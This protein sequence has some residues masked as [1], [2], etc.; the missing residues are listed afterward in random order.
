LKA[1][2]TSGGL[3]NLKQWFNFVALAFILVGNVTPV[4][5]IHLLWGEKKHPF[6]LKYAS[7]VEIVDKTNGEQNI[8]LKRQPFPISFDESLS[9]LQISFDKKSS[10]IKS[11]EVLK[12]QYK[13]KEFDDSIGEAASFDQPLHEM[14]VAPADF[15]FLNQEKNTGDFTIYFR[16][17]PYQLKRHMDVF[18]KAGVFEGRKQGLVCGWEGGKLFYDF[19][20]LF[21]NR[22]NPVA[23][24]RISTR[25]PFQANRFYSV[26]LIY[27]QNDGSLTLYLDGVEQ[28]KIYVTTDFSPHGGIL[29]P[30]FH[31][32][33][34]SP[35]IIGKNY[36][37]ALDDMIFSN[38][39]LNPEIISGRFNRVEKKGARFFQSPGVAVSNRIDLPASQSKIERLKYD[40]LKPQGTDVKFYYRYSDRPFFADIDEMEFPYLPLASEKLVHVKGKYFQW[41]AEL[42]ADATG[43]LT[44]VVNKVNLQYS[45]NMAP[46]APGEIS[47]LDASESEVT[48]EFARSL[49][50]DVVD[51]GR[52]HV[53]YG[54]KP[55]Q[56]LGAI[57]YK[58]FTDA[59]GRLQGVPI[60]D[61][62]KW[63]TDDQRFQN[64]IKIT[65]SNEIISANYSYFKQN[66]ELLYQYPLLQ[67]DIPYY[68]WV[69]TCDKL[70]TEKMAN[71]DHESKPSPYVVVR[72]R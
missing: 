4:F 40:V 20:N 8:R 52:Y 32:W 14:W 58:G 68:F 48:L 53:Y 22:E 15:L 10:Y 60:T 56:P 65:I 51:G 67:K 34:K 16:M 1:D 39:L 66:P 11:G 43:E 72:L 13:L 2:D 61:G 21:W 29:V 31:K 70:W 46:T 54:L 26:M 18:Q 57:K 71:S 55:Y 5:S 41:K 49:E 27:R 12:A 59:S 30:K 24:L 23:N 37:G 17:R 7:D 44:P 28:E 63:I 69:T 45:V 50:M 33:D 35:L 64:R 25:D 19:Y 9:T 38:H 36:L 6:D 47:V 3:K 42:Y 62:D